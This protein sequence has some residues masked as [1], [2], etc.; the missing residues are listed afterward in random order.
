MEQKDINSPWGHGFADV[1]S[2]YSWEDTESKIYAS[3]EEDVRRVLSKAHRNTQQLT[4]ED[5]MV[6]ISPAA[7]N[8]L[9]EMAQLS[10]RFT[11][12]RFGKT[13]SMY[14]PM[15][16]SNAC[17]NFC[18]YCGFNHNNPFKRT[19]LTM[20]Q[21]ETECK[22]IKKLGPFQ[23]LLI[24]SGEFPSL[25]GVEYFENVLKTCR[26]YFHNLSIEVQPLKME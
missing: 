8:F 19:V 22:A 7:E 1:I 5:F 17:S 26:P 3:T 6:L 15:Y 11:Q 14:I 16:V 12:E 21:V 24:V 13:I 9:E 25:C 23:N 18:V 2:Q 20:E 4:P 10:Q